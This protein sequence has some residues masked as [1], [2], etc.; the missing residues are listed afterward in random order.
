MIEA[1]KPVPVFCVSA[2]A[3]LSL[4]GCTIG[5][6]AT[7]AA[8]TT[9]EESVAEPAPSETQA[10]PPTSA[11]QLE[12][13]RAPETTDVASAE[14]CDTPF[15]AEAIGEPQNADRLI[16]FFCDG[17]WAHVGLEQTGIES[18]LVWENGTWTW[19]ESDGHFAGVGLTVDC[20]LPETVNAHAPVPEEI[21]EA[22][23]YCGP[24]DV[25]Y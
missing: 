18:F 16:Q 23:Y 12:Q 15:I 25:L 2:L 7:D 6:G 11:P 3:S 9:A 14:R 20:H 8:P 5:D 24:D 21:E 10:P 4:V 17:Q 19:L 13:T 1:M 22:V